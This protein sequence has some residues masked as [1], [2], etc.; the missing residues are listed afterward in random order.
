MVVG[1]LSEILVMPKCPSAAVCIRVENILD[2][3]H[4]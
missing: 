4:K 1:A 3:F 2:L